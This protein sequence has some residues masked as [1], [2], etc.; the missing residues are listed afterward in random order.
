MK[1]TPVV[2]IGLL[3]M[4]ISGLGLTCRIALGSVGVLTSVLGV[5]VAIVVLLGIHSCDEEASSR[6][7]RDHCE[8]SFS[9]AFVECDWLVFRGTCFR[10]VPYPVAK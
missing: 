8:S 5:G 6:G 4:L 3:I 9:R 1:R 7:I 2:L 10:S